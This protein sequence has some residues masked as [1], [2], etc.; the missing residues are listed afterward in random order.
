MARFFT[1]TFPLVVSE[2]K[3]FLLVAASAMFLPAV[4]LGVWVDHSHTALNAIAPAAVR[5][6]YV[7]HDFA[8]YY[9]SQPSV[10]FASE[11]YLNNFRVSF[12]A[13]ALGITFGLGTLV[14]LFFN[15]VNI[16]YA[17]GMFYAAH[18]A[19]EFWGLVTPHGLLE[20]TSVTLAGAAG[21]RLGWALV[22]PGNRPRARALAYEGRQAITLVLGTILTLGVS[23]MIEGFVTGSA[24]PTTLRVGIGAAVELTFLAWVV[25]CGRA[26][27]A[28]FG[29]SWGSRARP[30]AGIDEN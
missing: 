20:L 2:S 18:H 21:L 28:R 9:S 5:Q 17:A 15:G 24:L 25:L 13:F 26:A 3:W 10:L 30:A 11:V 27:H 8:R 4:V 12:E 6:A 7:N 16:G 29:T 22:D 14:I 1:A 23:G 19:S